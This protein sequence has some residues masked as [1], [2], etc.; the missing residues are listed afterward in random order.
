M[1]QQ[2]A[3]PWPQAAPGCSCPLWQ[4]LHTEALFSNLSWDCSQGD[5][6]APADVK[7]AAVLSHMKTQLH[8]QAPGRLR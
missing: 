7:A 6:L 8:E 3:Q 2:S 4:I 5:R 1:C